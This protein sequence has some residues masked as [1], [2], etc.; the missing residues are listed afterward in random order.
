MNNVDAPR[1]LFAGLLSAAVL[2]SNVLLLGHARATDH[3]LVL[4]ISD[5]RH[6]KPLPGVRHDRKSALELAQRLGYDT[7]QARVLSDAELAGDGIKR[8]VT[9]LTDRVREGDRLFLYYSGHGA[10]FPVDGG[11]AEALVPQDAGA[12][13][14]MP[15]LVRTSELISALDG[16]RDKLL[17]AFV[18]F[19]A[20][21]SGGLRDLVASSGTSARSGQQQVAA[22]RLTG[23]SVPMRG[24]GQ[25]LNVA[26]RSSFKAYAPPA[27]ALAR[28]MNLSA[29]RNFTFVAAARE[30]EEALD[31]EDQGGLA[32]TA[33]LQ[34]ARSGVANIS[35][36]GVVSVDELRACAQQRINALVPTITTVHRP[37]NLEVYSNVHKAVA[38][39]AAATVPDARPLTEA[40]RVANVFEQVASNSNPNLGAGAWFSRSRVPLGQPVDLHHSVRSP[41]FLSVLYVGS[42]Q[43]DIQALLT[44]HPV[45]PLGN[46]LLGPTTITE[47]A[48]DNRFL[49]LYTREPL[50]LR[51]VLQNAKAG[52]KVSLSAA[53]TQSLACAAEGQRNATPFVGASTP[54][55][56]MRNAT[57]FAPSKDVNGGEGAP[58]TGYGA[59]LLTVRGE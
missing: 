46:T 50:N 13:A 57:A 28:G 11:C 21:H 20:C 48:G 30:D 35:G 55:S 40:Q 54:C 14:G 15:S 1:V 10:S 2:L 12:A 58:F 31:L 41:G 43:K 56:G 9:A 5:Y 38:N 42:D 7:R 33:L 37:H 27:D 26:N 45:R 25:C 36:T 3:V 4:T 44:N 49:V 52:Q 32:T 17:D 22:S 34:C 39:V 51:A 29:T 23:K 18:F 8:A 19:D 53:V 59:W 24:S 6:V 16:V 47:P